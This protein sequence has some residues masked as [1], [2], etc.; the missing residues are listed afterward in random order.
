MRNSKTHGR[1]LLLLSDAMAPILAISKGRSSA[2]G[3]MRV[4]RRVAALALACNASLHIRWIASERNPADSPSRRGLRHG[5]CAGEVAEGEKVAHRPGDVGQATCGR[6]LAAG[7]TA[8]PPCRPPDGVTCGKLGGHRDHLPGVA[9]GPAAAERD[10]EDPGAVPRRVDGVRGV[11]QLR[12]TSDLGIDH[13]GG[14]RPD[15]GALLR[16]ALP[17]REAREPRG[18]AAVSSML[19][20][21]SLGTT[22]RSVAV[23]IS[24]GIA[25]LEPAHSEKEQA[26]AAV[27]GGVPDR[28]LARD[29][30]LLASSIRSGHVGRLLS[31]A[32]RPAR[33]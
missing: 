20:T 3:M 11:D 10:C 32:Q 16:C 22:K 18:K 30:R 13:G 5:A 26:S 27:G 24:S 19:P 31:A 14:A 21:S 2:K 25:W 17:P 4:C 8:R 23:R 12:V 1:N 15:A 33:W 29:A 28:E 9:V 6:E 7:A